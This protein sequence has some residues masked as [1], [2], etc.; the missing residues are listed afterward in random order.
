MITSWCNSAS[1]LKH[2]MDEAINS[3]NEIDNAELT[4]AVQC[5]IDNLATHRTNKM[6][7]LTLITQNIRSIYGNL[8]S[9][10]VTLANL[11]FNVDI[12]VL[13]ECRLVTGKP[14]PCP[15]NYNYFIT[16]HNMNQNDGVVIYIK[17]SLTANV[18]EIRL[19]NASCI[20]ITIKNNI[21][22]GIYRSP[23]EKYADKFIN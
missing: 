8:D 10:E 22:L 6:N 17:K 12:M 21:I 7:G 11:K 2:T 1:I 15:T 9:L 4:H 18:K 13:T 16:S 5:D 19:V 23:S 14:V 3:V 20:Q